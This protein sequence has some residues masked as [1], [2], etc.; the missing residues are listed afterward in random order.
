MVMLEKPSCHSTTCARNRRRL[1]RL[2]LVLLC[3]PAKPYGLERA[4]L[5]RTGVRTERLGLLFYRIIF[6]DADGSVFVGGL[7]RLL[8]K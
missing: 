5:A 4:F 3:V 8:I 6:D 1:T 2:R 7:T